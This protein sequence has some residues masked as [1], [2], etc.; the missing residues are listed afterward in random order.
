M[1]LYFTANFTMKDQLSARKIPL[2]APEHSVSNYKYEQVK[3]NTTFA[4]YLENAHDIRIVCIY[5]SKH[6]KRISSTD[7]Q[8]YALTF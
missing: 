5:F 1:C 6:P 2:E 7:C 3:I 4:C 8:L